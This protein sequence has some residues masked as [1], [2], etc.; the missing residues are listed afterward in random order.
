MSKGAIPEETKHPL[1]LS[2]NQHISMLTLKHVHENLGHSGRIHTLSTVRKK[3]WI[4]NA[5]SDS[6]RSLPIVVFVDATIG[7]QWNKR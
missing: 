1:V 2:K 6:E 4:T 3:F 5:N 7:K